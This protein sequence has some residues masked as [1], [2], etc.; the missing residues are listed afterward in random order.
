MEI[1][2]IIGLKEPLTKLIETVFHGL[3]ELYKPIH[4]KRIAKARAKEISIVSKALCD[5]INIPIN[6]DNGNINISTNDT[7]LLL[8]R[9]KHRLSFQEIK[10]QQNIES[11][12]YMAYEILKNLISVSSTPVDDDWVNTFF[13]SV[14]NVS[15]EQ[16]Q[17]IWS[18]ILSGEIE[19]P[20]RFSL[21]TLNTL[22]M[23]TQSDALNIENLSKFS[24]NIK[25]NQ[26][27]IYDDELLTEFGITYSKLLYLEDI[28]IIQMN[29]G[30]KLDIT[31]DEEYD[32]IN[33]DEF[34]IILYSKDQL[35]HN[36]EIPV[37]KF[38]SVGNEIVSIFSSDKNV[39]Y[40]KKVLL[41]FREKWNKNN[42]C[43]RLNK[44]EENE[45]PTMQHQ[46]ILNED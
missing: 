16:M 26:I 28:G 12:V 7:E 11:V 22:K 27:V 25:N 24:V 38:T 6:Y 43:V 9:A 33:N 42:V 2:D 3:G 15:N 4:I 40:I 5:N 17:I 8:L 31:V 14:A 18:R 39:E 36:I 41:K 1:T 35:K 13:D 30:M 45:E 21:R 23:L 29:T 46:D 37:I 19:K 44:V 32:G 20:G 34:K 10:K